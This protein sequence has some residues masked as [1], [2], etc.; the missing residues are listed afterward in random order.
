M[1]D[2]I[3]AIYDRAL[4]DARIRYWGSVLFILILAVIA[5]CVM[6]GSPPEEESYESS[7]TEL[8]F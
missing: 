8:R 7:T 2:D 5:V 6:W 1:M 3:D 4:R